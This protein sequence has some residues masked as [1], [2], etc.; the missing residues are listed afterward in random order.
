VRVKSESGSL[1]FVSLRSHAQTHTLSSRFFSNF[2]PIHNPLQ[3][4][5]NVRFLVLNFKIQSTHLALFPFPQNKSK[6]IA[7]L[8]VALQKLVS[9]TFHDLNLKKPLWNA[10]DDLGYYIPTTIQAASFNVMM[11]GKDT[12]G[13]VSYTHLRAHET[14]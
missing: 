7:N 4:P 11:S 13:T 1:H 5:I 9:M 14:G 8:S 6:A 12:I 2:L 10:L 3:I